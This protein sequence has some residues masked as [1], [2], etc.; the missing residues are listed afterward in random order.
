M[1][2]LVNVLLHRGNDLSSF[3]LPHA[4][5]F[6]RTILEF[7]QI[8]LWNPTQ[9]GGVPYLADPQNF[10]FYPPNYLLLFLPVETAFLI[11]LFGHLVL[12]GW[13]TYRLAKKIFNLGKIPAIFSGL[14]FALSPLVFAHL[15][16]G[17]YTMI[18]AVSWLPWFVLVALNFLEKP[19]VRKSLGLAFT[20]FFMYLNYVNIAFFA[21]LF[22]GAYSLFYLWTHR[23][24]I[25][26]KLYATCYVLFAIVFLGLI[27]PL[28]F[29]QLELAPLSTRN[30][31]TFEDV[32]QPV[33][34]LKLFAKNLFFPYKLNPQEMAT[35]RV[36]FPGLIVWALSFFGFL[37]LKDRSRWFYLGWIGFSALFAL[38][39]R[40]PLF[41]LLYTYVPFIAAMRIPTRIWV[42]SILLIAIFAGVGLESVFRRKSLS[43]LSMLIVFLALLEIAIVNQR[44][45]ARPL[46]NGKL[47]ESFYSFVEK[48]NTPLMKVYCTTGCFSVERLGKMGVSSLSG[49]NPAQL[50]SFVEY[51]Q[52]AGGYHYPSYIPVLPP[53][54]T[55]DRQPQPS[56]EKLGRLNTRYIGSPYP[57][58]DPGLTLVYEDNGYYLYHNRLAAPLWLEKEGRGAVVRVAANTVEI[59]VK[60]NVA[61]TVYVSELYYP[62][63]HAVDQDGKTLTVS[64][65]FPFRGVEVF[66]ETT[67]ASFYYWPTSLT[68]ALS[69][70]ALTL[71]VSLYA[72]RSLKFLLRLGRTRR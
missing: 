56:A 31:L 40:T 20:L 18:A 67:R 19:S 52:E 33:W 10:L 71:G 5:F 59:E 51:L 3:F 13:G 11:L 69:I 16:A 22:F 63:W 28:L 9:L 2:W 25:S 15:E 8:P 37:K 60:T 35:E 12:A 46:E 30:R 21:F 48:E 34:S 36:L 32:A 38:G 64:N 53:Y 39:A 23:T 7:H 70:F 42:L 41:G 62:G 50:E 6:K 66:P 27:A 29:S 45:F 68:I 26:L 43:K 54:P 47:P 17:H 4:Y 24:K 72:Y 55:F 14:L 1:G 44:I 65:G 49:N 61:Q 57:L 58:S